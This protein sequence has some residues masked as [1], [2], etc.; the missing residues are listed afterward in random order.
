MTAQKSSGAA[1][2][3]QL[4]DKEQVKLLRF[5]NEDVLPT[6]QEQLQRLIDLQRGAA[7]GATQKSNVKLYFKS[8]QGNPY[9]VE[10][11]IWAVTEQNISLKGEVM[12]PILSVYK[13]GL[14]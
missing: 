4:I 10:A 14:F 3:A 11:T 6:K 12:I 9:K 2:S 1:P 7:L 13:V 8:Y 5:S